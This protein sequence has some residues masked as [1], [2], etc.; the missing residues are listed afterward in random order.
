MA[1][2]VATTNA[3]RT[4]IKSWRCTSQ[5]PCW[6]SQTAHPEEKRGSVNDITT[7]AMTEMTDSL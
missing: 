6:E 2:V 5:I 4:Q 1:L 7:M 3:V